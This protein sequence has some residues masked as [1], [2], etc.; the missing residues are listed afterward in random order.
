MTRK[1]TESRDDN[2]DIY[3]MVARYYE[4]KLAAHGA[5]PNGVD[6][7]DAASQW[8]RHQQFDR[9]IRTAEEG[10]IAD[11]GCG[12]GGYLSFL[13][14]TGYSGFYRGYDIS[15]EMIA[16]AAAEHGTGPDRQWTVGTDLREPA[17][18]VIASGIFNVRGDVPD[19]RWKAYIADTVDAMAAVALRGFAFNI[20]TS[21]SDA[22]RM[23]P[24]LYYANPTEWF[25]HCTA[26]FGRSVAVLQDYGLYEFTLICRP[27]RD[28]ASNPS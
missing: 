1:M 17:D 13:R 4:S 20:L 10:S 27:E 22:G 28:P 7:R 23:R 2:S 21:W 6:W 15:A 12:Y 26:R 3:G 5:T 14:E 11:L 16:A 18:Y 9:L 8:L 25:D 19:Y 24:D